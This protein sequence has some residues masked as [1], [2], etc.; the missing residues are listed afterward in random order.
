MKLAILTFLE[1]LLPEYFPLKVVIMLLVT[2]SVS[3][4]W[5]V[6]CELENERIS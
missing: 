1:S 3:D 2:M 4:K 5:S 6:R